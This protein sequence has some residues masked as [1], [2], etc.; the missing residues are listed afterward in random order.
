VTFG[1][2]RDRRE[3]GRAT[4][5]RLQPVPGRRSPLCRL[6]GALLGDDGAVERAAGFVELAAAKT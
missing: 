3:R 5:D 1:E 2:Q 4:T 6:L